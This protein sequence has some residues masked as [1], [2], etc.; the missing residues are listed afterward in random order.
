[1]MTMNQSAY[2]TVCLLALL[3]C[4]GSAEMPYGD[5]GG[6]LDN[7]PISLDDPSYRMPGGTLTWLGPGGSRNADAWQPGERISD[8]E[9]V[10]TPPVPDFRVDP[11][12]TDQHSAPDERISD[13]E[14]DA[15]PPIPD[16]LI[17][18]EPTT[19]RSEP[20]EWI[21]NPQP[22]T[23]PPVPDFLI[24]PE[25]SDGGTAPDERISYPE[26]D[27]TPCIPDTPILPEPSSGDT[28]PGERIS[29]PV[30]G[31]VDPN[32]YPGSS[33]VVRPAPTP[34]VRS[35]R[36]YPEPIGERRNHYPVYTD[37]DP[38]YRYVSPSW[39]TPDRDY[40]SDPYYSPYYYRTGSLQIV[41]TP[42]KA[43]VWLN[44]KFRGKTPYSG[45]L[46]IDNLVPGSYDL[47]V[48]YDGYLPYTRTIYIAR[49]EVRTLNIVLEQVACTYRYEP[50][51]QTSSISIKSEP[52]GASLLLDNEYRGITPVTL[53]N[54]Q[55]GEHTVTLQKEG[56]TDFITRVQAV[57]GQTLPI[58]AIMAKL[59]PTPEP[60]V[61]PARV[62]TPVP[63]ATRAD[64]PGGIAVLSLIAGMI[65]VT[66]LQ[67]R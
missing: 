16:S 38:P 6:D 62:Q 25:P 40:Y 47:L 41:S 46:D 66:R 26:P 31:T 57:Q 1:M 9:P 65:A 48:R 54:T 33:P 30:Q 3:I 63:V 64:L 55:P 29:D 56:Y 39:C 14:P 24:H 2:I 8:P 43:E 50:V 21:S 15:T 13:P 44:N 32:H 59:P 19:H 34:E 58:T 51:E 28:N 20:G 18:P 49:N 60:S 12:P 22:V 10:N 35:F 4:T 67:K 23:T 17:Q 5:G 27:Y 52:A 42:G 61:P 11:E 37:P 45:Y 53:K 36:P 7:P